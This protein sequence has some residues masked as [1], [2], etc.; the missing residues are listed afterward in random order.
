MS[1]EEIS[2][3]QWRKIT[4]MATRCHPGTDLGPAQVHALRGHASPL[5]PPES[6]RIMNMLLTRPDMER[7]CVFTIDNS[8]H[9]LCLNKFSSWT[10]RCWS[11]AQYYQ[12]LGLQFVLCFCTHATSLR[13]FY[14]ILASR[15]LHFESP[16]ESYMNGSGKDGSY[17]SQY[18]KNWNNIL[19]CQANSYPVYL[20]TLTWFLNSWRRFL[21]ISSL[22]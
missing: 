19:W 15:C 12:F 1:P 3:A 16:N 17:M 8:W 4:A 22:K 6:N 13:S 20:L 11:F 9:N 21:N 2:T 10:L 14:E 18:Y 5:L 7:V